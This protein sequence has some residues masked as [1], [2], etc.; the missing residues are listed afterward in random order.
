MRVSWLFKRSQYVFVAFECL[1]MREFS[2]WFTPYVSGK[3]GAILRLGVQPCPVPWYKPKARHISLPRHSRYL[4][5][6]LMPPISVKRDSTESIVHQENWDHGIGRAANLLHENATCD[7]SLAQAFR[8]SLAQEGGRRL[9]SDYRRYGEHG[10]RNDSAV[11][12]RLDRSSS[13]V[14]GGIAVGGST[15]KW[16]F[17]KCHRGVPDAPEHCLHSHIRKC[18]QSVRSPRACAGRELRFPPARYHRHGYQIGD[19]LH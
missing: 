10:P 11:Q 3:V 13:L 14:S 8:L 1:W 15:G 9:N 12:S 2:R 19:F 17:R 5:Y 6:I 16:S 4:T 18:R 7:N